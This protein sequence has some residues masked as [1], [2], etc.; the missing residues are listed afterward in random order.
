[1]TTK[2]EV[3]NH[4]RDALESALPEDGSAELAMDNNKLYLRMDTQVFAV[5]VEDEEQLGASERAAHEFMASNPSWPW[6]TI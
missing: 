6:S 4:M 5:T 3:D 1:M 2:N